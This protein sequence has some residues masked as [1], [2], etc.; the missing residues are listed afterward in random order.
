[1]I[2][3]CL[4]GTWCTSS[5][6]LNPH[7]YGGTKTEGMKFFSRTFLWDHQKFMIGCWPIQPNI[8]Y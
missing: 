5:A 2:D 1:M 7:K 4:R 8:I 3:I 6:S